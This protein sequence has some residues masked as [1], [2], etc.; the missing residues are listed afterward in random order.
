MTAS[1]VESLAEGMTVASSGGGRGGCRAAP[2]RAVPS[3][4]QMA[5]PVA[6]R[7]ARVAT[8]NPSRVERKASS[9]CRFVPGAGKP[10]RHS[11]V[12]VVDASEAQ[13]VIGVVV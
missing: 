3:D 8:R 9:M 6:Q 2:R 13:N 1:S 5:G 12:E 4:T 11:A 10:P 7:W